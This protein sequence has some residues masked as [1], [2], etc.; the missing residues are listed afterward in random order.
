MRPFG[1]YY[2]KVYFD[3][4][5]FEG[6]I[7][8]L[9]CALQGIRPERMVF[10][11]DYPQDFTGVNTDTG[12]GM[13]E[14][15]NYIETIR[16]LPLDDKSIKKILGDTAAEL[17]SFVSLCPRLVERIGQSRLSFVGCVRAPTEITNS[18][19]ERDALLLYRSTAGFAKLA[20]T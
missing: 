17:L 3:M 6:G 10:A 7:A 8:A 19:R 13:K 9:N 20:S 12:K 16:N 11:S 2:D 4:A 18:T 1:E 15:R 14:L 5:G